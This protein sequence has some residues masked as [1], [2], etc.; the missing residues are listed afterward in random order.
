MQRDLKIGDIVE[1]GKGED[2]DRGWVTAIDIGDDG[3]PRTAYVNWDSGVSTPC[4]AQD[5]EIVGHRE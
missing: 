3:A 5:L 2:F 4:P 1:A